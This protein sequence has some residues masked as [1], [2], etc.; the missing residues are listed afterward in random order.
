MRFDVRC[1]ERHCGAAWARL[2]EPQLRTV[3]EAHAVAVHLNSRPKIRRE[4]GV[5]K[6]DYP[7]EAF[8]FHVEEVNAE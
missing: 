7:A 6:L 5:T 8:I 1:G 4:D 2:Q 3:L